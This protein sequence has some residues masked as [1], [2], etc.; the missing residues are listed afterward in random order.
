VTDERSGRELEP[1]PTGRELAPAPREHGESSVERFYAG[2]SAHTIGLTEERAAGIVRQSGNARNIAFLGTLLVVL[3]VPLYWFYELGVPAVPNTSRLEKET[4][5]QQVTDVSRGY[6]LYLANC[7]QCHGNNGEG[8][9]GPPLNNQDRLYNAVT[10]AGQPGPG[11]LNPDYIRDVLTVG[12]R[13]VCGDPN[14][15][16]PVWAD[17]N[18][19]PLNYRQIEELIAFLTASN[20]ITFEYQPEHA[21]PGQT[22]PP[23]VKVSGWRDPN[24]RPPAGQP[25]P[26]ACWRD[27]DGVQIGANTGGTGAGGGG[28]TPTIT[29]PGTAA[30]PRVIKVIET[31]TLEITDDKG[32]K[33]TAIPVKKGETVR[34]QVENSAGFAHNFYVGTEADLQAN[35]RANLKGVPDFNSGTKEF[36][37]TFDSDQKLQFACI[38]P[39]HYG[40]MHGDIQVVQ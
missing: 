4:Q 18:G 33:L 13:I 10:P 30:R 26:P 21:E 27:P 20:E 37:M 34:F 17:V 38:V 36:T 28:G 24:Y 1:R 25:S 15:I 35:A 11:H 7:A 23:P 14:S 2:E 39:G 3:F 8:G 9:V 29:N 22:L 16:M 19:G 6:E 40:P 5:A 12:G 31:A 32:A